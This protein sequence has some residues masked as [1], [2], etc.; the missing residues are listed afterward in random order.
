MTADAFV[1]QGHR[2]KVNMKSRLQILA[3]EDER[4][5]VDLILATLA[6]AN[7]DCQMVQV[8]TEPDFVDALEKGS[9]DLIL[10]DHSLPT[11]DGLS[12]LKIAVE[13]APGVPFIF[14][15]GS[16]G[17]ELAIELIKSGA[18]D[19]V[20]KDR[21]SRLAPAVRRAVE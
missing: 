5:D 18:T 9:I 13:K 1:A 15:S 19:Y 8:E 16:M 7:I 4:A 17:E 10:S 12:A 11:F 21:L 3:L 14:V 2:A 6:K 20:L